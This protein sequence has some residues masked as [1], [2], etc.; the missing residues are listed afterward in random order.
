MNRA[1]GEMLGD[2]QRIVRSL[3]GRDDLVVNGDMTLLTDLEL[4]SF[5]LMDFAVAIEEE[6]GIEIPDN[7]IVGF[8]TVQNVQDYIAAH[9]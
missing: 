8:R 3:T 4:N 6:Y 2:L 7:D 5:E 9:V 1:K